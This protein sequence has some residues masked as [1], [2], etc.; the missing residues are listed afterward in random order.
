MPEGW[1]WTTLDKV[2]SIRGG[3]RIPKGKTFAKERTAHVYI[4]VTDMK[5]MTVDTCGLKYIDE[6]VFD[7]INSYIIEK[8][9]LYLT[10]AGTIGK[11]GTRTEELYG[12]NRTAN[13]ART[14]DIV[15]PNL[16]PM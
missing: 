15:G 11:V 12:L 14:T 5:N 1:A 13:A 4:R 2:C 8:D 7:E 16:Y 3:K 6:E 9:D 10:I